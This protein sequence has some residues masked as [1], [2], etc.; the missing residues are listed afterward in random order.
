MSFKN[1]PDAGRN[2]AGAL[3]GYKDQQPVVLALP[4]GGMSI[5]SLTAVTNAFAGRSKPSK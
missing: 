2:L 4:R 1:R 5:A 3:A